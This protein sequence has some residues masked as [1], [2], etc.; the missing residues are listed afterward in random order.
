MQ[1]IVDNVIKKNLDLRKVEEVVALC[2]KIGIKVSCFFVIGLIGETKQDI[3]ATINFAYKL[4]RLGADKFYFSYAMPLYGTE[5]YNQAV[6]GGFLKEDFDDDALSSVQPLIETEEFT[7][8]D[9]QKLCKKAYAVNPVFT[10]E[11][12]KRVL[13]NPGI[14]LNILGRITR[15]TSKVSKAS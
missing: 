14:V 3:E 8:E 7:V 1:K 5:L 13:K 4:R 11:K 10:I 15:R 12:F 2:R 9:L 6:K